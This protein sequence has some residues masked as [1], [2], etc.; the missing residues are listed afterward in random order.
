MLELIAGR[1]E[2]NIRELEGSLTRVNAYAKLNHCDINE[3]VISLALRDINIH[4][5]PKRITPELV[6]QNIGISKE[7]NNF[8]LI[9]ALA[10]KDVLKANRIAQY[11][12]KNPKSNPIQMTL[13]VL[14][15]YFSNLL[16]CYYTKD[17]SEAGLMTALGLRGTFQVKDYLLGMRNY[18]AMKV[19]NLISD[20][21]MTDAR[22]KGV[23]NTSV[24]DAELLKELLYKI[25]H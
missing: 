8:E 11:F 7:Y 13:P 25:L 21:R 19:F 16:I 5:D 17:R 20:I 1:I 14:F 3:E 10:M 15:N 22:S 6:E 2:S 24:S 4:R 9:K 18:S 23:E 12:E